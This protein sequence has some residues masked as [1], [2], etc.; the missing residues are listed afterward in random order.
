MDQFSKYIDPE[1]IFNEA[2]I[3]FVSFK[4]DGEIIKANCTFYSFFDKTERELSSANF[5]KLLTKGSALYFQMV[6]NPLLNLR[7][8]T[9]EI[10]L[11]FSTPT[12]N[13][14]ALFNA[15]AYKDEHGK[16]IVVNAYLL[17]IIDRKKYEAELL[18][19]KRMAEDS[20][21][22]AKKIIDDNNEQFMKIALNQ[23]HMIRRP[24]ANMLGLI[25]ILKDIQI[26][27]DGADLIRLLE[28]S[29]EELDTQIKEIVSQTQLPL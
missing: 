19:A 17:K 1:F 13:F 22:S 25:S 18:L 24:M 21:N 28:T 3:G 8:Y 10:S 16:V 2:P 9:N 15:K 27:E 6:L 12:E 4:P 5:L 23:S 20:L 26:S 29:A 14:D 7:E 11:S